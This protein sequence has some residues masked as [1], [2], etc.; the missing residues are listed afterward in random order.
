MIFSQQ[1]AWQ[2]D[3]AVQQVLVFHN[4]EDEAKFYK[5]FTARVWKH[6]QEFASENDIVPL[7]KVRAVRTSDGDYESIVRDETGCI[8][9]SSFDR[10]D[11]SQEAITFGINQMTERKWDAQ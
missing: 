2:C 6:G 5:E 3:E 8:V 7:F 11:T 10:Y 4:A 1:H 9:I